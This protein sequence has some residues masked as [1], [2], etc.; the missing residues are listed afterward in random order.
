M[1]LRRVEY[2]SQ[3]AAGMTSDDVIR[4]GAVASRSNERAGITGWLTYDGTCFFQAIEGEEAAIAALY[5]KVLADT[6][7]HD[8]V[9]LINKP[10]DR[11]RFDSF[12][13]SIASSGASEARS[14]AWAR[15]DSVGGDSDSL[16]DMVNHLS[17][18]DLVLLGGNRAPSPS[19]PVASAV[20][21]AAR[22]WQT[23]AYKI[24]VKQML[25][26]RFGSITE[27]AAAIVEM[28]I[29]ANH[30]GPAALPN[31]KAFLMQR[32]DLVYQDIGRACNKLHI[33]AFGRGDALDGIDSLNLTTALIGVTSAMRALGETSPGMLK[34]PTVRRILVNLCRA[35]LDSEVDAASPAEPPKGSR[36]W[37]ETLMG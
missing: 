35:A 36:G 16:D 11:R 22:R 7:H 29:L 33:G 6:R 20:E 14:D 9:T 12:S 15:Q 10:I 32:S 30:R 37:L 24:F 23:L 25:G 28:V 31:L 8:V 17:L 26:R 21:T 5:E 1:G 34:T 19:A 3:A 13:I 4:F 27:V 18:K 2:Y